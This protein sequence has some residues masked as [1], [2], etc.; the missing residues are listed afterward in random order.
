MHLFAVCKLI[1]TFPGQGN[2]FTYVL[3][4]VRTDQYLAGDLRRIYSMDSLDNILSLSVSKL[5]F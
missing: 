2:G 4:C 3:D 5:H 1:Q